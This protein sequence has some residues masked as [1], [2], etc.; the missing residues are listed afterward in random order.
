ML[1]ENVERVDKLKGTL[2]KENIKAVKW[3]FKGRNF[4]DV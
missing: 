2:L 1:E 4:L 3:Y